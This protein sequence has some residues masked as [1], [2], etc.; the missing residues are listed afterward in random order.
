[1]FESAKL[2]LERADEHVR[3]LNKMFTA[4]LNTRP[5]RPV[6][7]GERDEG[8]VWRI[9]VE[10]I[11]DRTPPPEVALVLGDAIHNYRCVLDH[12]VW[13][14]VG[15]DRG[16]Q[17]RYLKFPTGA[18]RIDFESMALGM[19][20]PRQDTKDFIVSLAAY[21]TGNGKILHALN[22]LDNADKHT[23]TTPVTQMS[24]VEGI[25]LIHL[26]TGER[27]TIDPVYAD[28][29]GGNKLVFEAPAG[30]GI[31]TNYDIYP[32]PDIF[33]PEVQPFPGEPV[34]STLASISIKVEEVVN[35]FQWF[36]ANRV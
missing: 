36:V 29:S 2:K 14:L 10:V 27:K 7:K 31:D 6:I 11:V 20:T 22:L 23:V 34:T 26:E 1:M 5:H 24:F 15:I 12:L 16:T 30:F 33:F 13:E 4:F 32:T 3:D 8:N 17:D 25:T 28:I 9:S 19:K 35:A 21:E 18:N